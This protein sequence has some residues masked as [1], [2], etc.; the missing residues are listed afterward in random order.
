MVTTDDNRGSNTQIASHLNVEKWDM[1]GFLR[2]T[3]LNIRKM[4][5]TQSAQN[6]QKWKQIHK[7]SFKL[8]IGLIIG[9]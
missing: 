3:F 5:Q 4:T 7:T 9:Y 2:I 6:S 1:F 8:R